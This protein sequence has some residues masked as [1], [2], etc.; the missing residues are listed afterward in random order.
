M[1]PSLLYGQAISGRVTGR[2]IGVIDTIHLVEVARSA[3]L[4][5]D[6]HVFAST[7]QAAVKAWFRT[8]LDWI[9]THP[10]GK[11]ERGHPNNHG[12]C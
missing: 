4:L 12:V 2:S 5:G 9:N 6:A 7:D 8:Y 10:Y 3:K 1:N 11:K